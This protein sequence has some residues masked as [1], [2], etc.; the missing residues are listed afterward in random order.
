MN[1]IY[2]LIFLNSIIFGLEFIFQLDFSAIFG[3]NI[4]FFDGYFWQILTSM[5]LHANFTHLFM[6]MAV[7]FQIGLFLTRFYGGFKI[8]L[9][10][11][12]GGI[13]AN[14]F[15]LIYIFY[16]FENEKL[17]NIIGASG[18]VCVLLGIFA[19]LDKKAIIGIILSLVLISF[20]PLFFNI[21]IAWFSHFCGFGIGFLMAKFWKLK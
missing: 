7:L 9:I 11:I 10:Y 21:N 18:A 16:M 15:S 20:V 13:L 3:L 5:F 17:I 6:N 12:I 14:L 8:F 19:F 4:L 2:I 1:F